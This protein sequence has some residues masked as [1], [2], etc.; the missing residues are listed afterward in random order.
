VTR[1]FVRK[2]NTQIHDLLSRYDLVGGYVC[3]CERPGCEE[4]WVTL[5]P[6]QFA[7][8]LALPHC[9]LVAPGH[10]PRRALVVSRADGYLVVRDADVGRGSPPERETS[11][12]SRRALGHAPL[13][14]PTPRGV[15][16]G[17]QRGS[18]PG[19]MMPST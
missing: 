13:P 12:A 4:P 11:A 10:E 2:A 1:G 6:R 16:S 15:G 18:P 14:P 8:I 17:Q 5:S 19:D 9:Y 3:E 7:E